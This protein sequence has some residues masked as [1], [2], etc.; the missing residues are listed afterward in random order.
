MKINEF[1]DVSRVIKLFKNLE[2]QLIRS[3]SYLIYLK[4]NECIYEKDPL[5]IGG[6]SCQISEYNDRSGENIDLSDCYVAKEVVEAT[7]KIIQ[8]K[9][10]S[11]L[12]WLEEHGVDVG[13]R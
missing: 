1:E 9:I 12:D 5:F 4:E 11:V 10:E 6:S 3:N 13:E 7:T 8:K 2:R